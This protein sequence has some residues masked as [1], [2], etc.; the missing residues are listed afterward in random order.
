[1]VINGGNFIES[2]WFDVLLYLK[3]MLMNKTI[4]ILQIVIVYCDFLLA[5]QQHIDDDDDQ[6]LIMP[7]E[8][9]SSYQTHTMIINPRNN[10]TI[11]CERERFDIGK[12]CVDAGD[13]C[14]CV[15]HCCWAF[16]CRQW[17]VFAQCR[18]KCKIRDWSRF[19]QSSHHLSIDCN[20]FPCY[21]HYLISW[22]IRNVNQTRQINC[23]KH[24]CYAFNCK[25][26]SGYCR[27]LCLQK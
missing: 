8:S 21:E 14:Q 7:N 23:I 27:E 19:G 18:K 26:F 17:P 22:D 24:C 15:A 11:P 10:C 9:S 6:H 5:E 2:N 4:K 12:D 25:K 13:R 16:D 1:M 3:I 20:Y